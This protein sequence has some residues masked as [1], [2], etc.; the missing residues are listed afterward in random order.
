MSP[1]GLPAWFS[2]PLPLRIGSMPELL[3]SLEWVE[4]PFPVEPTPAEITALISSAFLRPT[5][6]RLI[7]ADMLEFATFLVHEPILPFRQS[8][9]EG[10]SLAELVQKA[11]GAM[12]EAYM[13][14]LAGGEGPLLL[15]TVPGA[16]IVGAAAWVL[17]STLEHGELQEQVLRWLRLRE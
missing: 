15:L 1:L 3:E 12:V 5:D 8:P 13:G 10:Q 4:G 9:I 11:P 7:A 2:S 14:F 16:V 17:A 6:E